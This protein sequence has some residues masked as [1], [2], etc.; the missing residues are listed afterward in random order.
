[1]LYLNLIL[2]TLS[3]P[4]RL[5]LEKLMQ[6]KQRELKTPHLDAFIK[7]IAPG[8]VALRREEFRE[9]G[10]EEGLRIAIRTVLEA[11]GVRLDAASARLLDAC[12]DRDRLLDWSR[13]AAVANDAREVFEPAPPAPAKRRRKK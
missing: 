13:R 12:S 2:A 9:E 5:K 1:M 6:S 3:E 10:R 4:T 7:R 11:R 8:V